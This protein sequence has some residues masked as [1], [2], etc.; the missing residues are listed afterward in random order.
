MGHSLLQKMHRN[1]EN[2]QYHLTINVTQGDNL[3]ITP[4]SIKQHAS[5]SMR[6]HAVITYSKGNWADQSKHE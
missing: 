5:P 1:H 6:G 3:L 2:P 4:L